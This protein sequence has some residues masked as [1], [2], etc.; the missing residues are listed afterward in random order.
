VAP[1]GTPAATVAKLNADVTAAF[2]DLTDKL[3]ELRL[4][5]MPGSPA[6]AARFIA[7]ETRLWG[8]VI[9]EAKITAQ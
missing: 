3:R 2:R 9:A 5:P 8:K 6:E 1:P 7:D 4:E